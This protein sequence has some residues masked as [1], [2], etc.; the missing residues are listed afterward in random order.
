M[1]GEGG[2]ASAQLRVDTLLL[3]AGSFIF[4]LDSRRFFFYWYLFIE[5]TSCLH[6]TYAI[7]R[8]NKRQSEAI[9][10]IFNLQLSIFNSGLSGLG[11]C[12]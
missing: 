4:I 3:V 6:M 8:L 2:R 5:I 9:L 11:I 7:A 12:A 1:N 10:Q